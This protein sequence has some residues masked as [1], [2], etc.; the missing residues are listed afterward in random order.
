LKLE[1]KNEVGDKKFNF[2]LKFNFLFSIFFT[3]HEMKE[4]KTS[5]KP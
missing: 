5:R 3:V 2:F 1:L 4:R